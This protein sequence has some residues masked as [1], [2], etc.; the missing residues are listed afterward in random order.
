MATVCT[1]SLAVGLGLMLSYLAVNV[2]DVI[3]LQVPLGCVSC[4]VVANAS[5]GAAKE[6]SGSSVAGVTHTCA[7]D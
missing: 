4:N 5:D 3:C 2:P 1:M 7:G 6:G